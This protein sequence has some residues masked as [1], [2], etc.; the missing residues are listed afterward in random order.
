M[1]QIKKETAF[2]FSSISLGKFLLRIYFYCVH[3]CG[4]K[5]TLKQQEMG[6]FIINKSN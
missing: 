5:S 6:S 1:Q 4:K 2:F 3:V